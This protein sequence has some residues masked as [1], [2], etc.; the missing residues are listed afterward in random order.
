LKPALGGDPDIGLIAEEVEQLVPDLVVYGYK[1]DWDG[2]TGL[3]KLDDEG[4]EI[5]DKS[6]VECY[7]VRYEKVGVYL[8][9]IVADHETTIKSLSAENVQLQARLDR[10]E[11]LLTKLASANPELMKELTDGTER[12]EAGKE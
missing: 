3:V 8:V 10:I 2:D 11:S 12:A 1:R 9:P 4:C 7:G 5:L 6:E